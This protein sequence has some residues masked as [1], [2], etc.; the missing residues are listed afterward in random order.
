MSSLESSD[1]E[2]INKKKINTQNKKAI[3]TI[4]K[5]VDEKKTVNKKTKSSSDDEDYEDASEENE[6]NEEIDDDEH[7]DVPEFNPT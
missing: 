2:I 7:L 3:K 4:K 6:E 1:S 5:T